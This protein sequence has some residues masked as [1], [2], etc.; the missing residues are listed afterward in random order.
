M[1]SEL[2]LRLGSGDA[3]A[4]PDVAELQGDRVR[5]ADGSVE[6]VDAIIYATGYRISFP[7]F[8][9]G[10]MSA[11]G[12]V[13]PLY[14]RMFKPGIDDLAFV[15]FGQ[16]IPTIFPFAE[17]QSKLAGRWLVGDWALPTPKPRCRT[18]SPP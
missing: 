9:P 17:C 7:F 11:P 13:L 4:K 14:K 2:L 3:T 5:F 18:R 8:D 1:S 15:G 12:N 16:A 6:P 10:F